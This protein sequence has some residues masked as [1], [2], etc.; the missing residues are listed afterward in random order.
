[1]RREVIYAASDYT[2]HIEYE[3]QTWYN[4]NINN[5]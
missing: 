3:T 2:G 5:K 1:M 4:K